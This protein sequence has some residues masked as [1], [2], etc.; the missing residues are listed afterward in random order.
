MHNRLWHILQERLA[1]LLDGDD[2]ELWIKPILPLEGSGK[3]I[4]LECPNAMHLSMVRDRYFGLMRKEMETLAPGVSLNLKTR[5]PKP[6]TTETSGQLAFSHKS[7]TPPVLNR[8]FIFDR[9]VPGGGNEL[10][11][12]AARAMARGQHI[13]SNS[14][15]LVS[16]TGLGKSHLT[17]AVGH[18]VL[19]AMPGLRVEYLTV[20]EFTNQMVSALRRKQMESFK[21]RYRR[22]CDLLLLE[23]VQFLSG[24]EKTQEELGYTLD[25]LMDAGKRVVFTSSRP[26][27]R[28]KG[29]KNGLESRLS[30]GITVS[31][32]PP[33]HSTRV[34]ILER[35][36]DSEGMHVN[37]EVLEYLA[38]EISGDVRRLQSAL[39]SL[40]TKGS[41]TNRPYDLELASEVLGQMYLRL[42]KISLDQVK[43][44]VSRLYGVELNVLTGKGRARAITKPRNLA[45][46]ICR[47]HTDA[48]YA[49]IGKAFNRDHAT[50]MYGVN[51]IERELDLDPRLKQE[52]NYLEQKLGVN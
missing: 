22:S 50:V 51:K 41:L 46:A 38:Q 15:F 42:K 40:L 30:S 28:I 31:I 35:F 10:A 8:R 4:T 17:Q 11:F 16:S 33:D 21:E 7:F 26:A 1:E 27:D 18:Q 49:A 34:R 29:L 47:R 3:A 52:F 48:S 2:L 19:S 44:L 32:E 13:F 39:V 9:F 37:T 6:K 36:L 24:K 5:G 25:N 43:S 20:E 12:A 14:L 45:M 23:E